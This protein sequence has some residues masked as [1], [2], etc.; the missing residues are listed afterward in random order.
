MSNSCDQFNL[1]NLYVLC[2]LSPLNLWIH[3]RNYNAKI[4]A[5]HATRYQ[6]EHMGTTCGRHFTIETGENKK[7]ASLDVLVTRT[8]NGQLQTEVYR[9]EKHR[10]QI[11][12]YHSNHPKCHRR[13]CV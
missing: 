8:T 12:N 10:D 4:G 2:H 13:S 5:D 11:L 7:F 6:I 1:L 9:K 3:R